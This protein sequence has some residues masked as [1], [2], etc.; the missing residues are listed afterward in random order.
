MDK[1][2]LQLYLHKSIPL[3]K[4]MQVT[5]E[6]SGAEELTL[7][8]PLEPNSNHHGTAFGG[9]IASLAVLAGWSLVHANTV[10][11]GLPCTLVV[12]KSEIHY[13][14]AIHSD[15][16]AIARMPG[17]AEW[18]RFINMLDKRRR[19]RIDVSVDVLDGSK[20]A[21][22]LLAQYAAAR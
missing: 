15:I 18:D 21:A 1:A 19:G 17:R 8:A 6:T 12:Q 11:A 22:K 13:K 20:V 4:H 16:R 5:V 14:A 10:K 2:E 3:T 9:S 7:A